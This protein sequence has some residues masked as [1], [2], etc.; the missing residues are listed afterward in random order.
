MSKRVEIII[1]EYP[2][3]VSLD[4][5]EDSVSIALQYNIDDVR[6]IEKKNTNHSKTITLAGTK[7]NNKAFGNL[8]DVNA[9]FTK[10]NPTKK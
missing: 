9:D 10:Y 3:Y 7:T 1:G 6:N 8:F 2:N 5:T 4:L